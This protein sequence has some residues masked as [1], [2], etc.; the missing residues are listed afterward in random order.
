SPFRQLETYTFVDGR[1]FMGTARANGVA[2]HADFYGCGVHRWR[3][4]ERELH[5]WW[6]RMA[7]AMGRPSPSSFVCSS[8]DAAF[9]V[10][11]WQSGA[12]AARAPEFLEV[13]ATSRSLT[14]I[15]SGQT[16][17]VTPVVA[18]AGAPVRMSDG[19]VERAG[20]DGRLRFV[21]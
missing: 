11:G 15:G 1:R 10:W 6:P 19:R 16:T 17:V 8:G 14:L 5:R 20:A 3:Y 18:T 13:R 12:E 4:W 9:A 2:L 7:R 21:V